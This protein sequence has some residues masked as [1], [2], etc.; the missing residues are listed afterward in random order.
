LKQT[1]LLFQPKAAIQQT[2]VFNQDIAFKS[3]VFYFEMWRSVLV[4][5]HVNDNSVKTTNFWHGS[6]NYFNDKN[7]KK[8]YSTKQLK[9]L[10]ML[11]LKQKH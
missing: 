7:V 6:N 8:K 3:S 5:K 2:V 10:L 1:S 9:I 11:L 4:E